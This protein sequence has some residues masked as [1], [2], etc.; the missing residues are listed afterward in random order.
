MTDSRDARWRAGRSVGGALAALA[1]VGLLAQQ[2]SRVNGLAARA[3]HL[4]AEHA[5]VTLEGERAVSPAV[6]AA[7]CQQVRERR[8]WLQGRM[9]PVRVTAYPRDPLDALAGLAAFVRGHRRAAREAGVVVKDDEWFGFAEF[10]QAGPV[11]ER[12]AA[13]WQARAAV[14]AVL[15][16]L[17]EARP[18]RLLSCR[19]VA[20]ETT[21]RVEVA[22]TGTSAALREF[23]NELAQSDQA[24]LVQSVQILAAERSG[25]AEP[26]GQRT[27]V[28]QVDVELAAPMNP[29]SA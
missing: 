13:V 28:V 23:L 20:A 5:R 18:D 27:V 21:E 12:M 3:R 9:L 8:D 6:L 14:G 25:D 7:Y 17:W 1:V 11:P 10:A 29:A 19:W 16:A 22:F 4:T 2:R 15:A 26:E 24:L